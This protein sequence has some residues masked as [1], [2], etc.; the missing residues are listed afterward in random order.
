M[1]AI[2]AT[3]MQTAIT[4]P[5][6]TDRSASHDLMFAATTPYGFRALTSE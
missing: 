6:G 1:S 3:M 5:R 4:S 2:S